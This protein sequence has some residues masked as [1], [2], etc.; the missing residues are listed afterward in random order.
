MGCGCGQNKPKTTVR[1]TPK[2]NDGPKKTTT[3]KRIIKK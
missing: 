1:V 3:T 2:T